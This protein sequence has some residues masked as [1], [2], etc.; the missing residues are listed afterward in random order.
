[1]SLICYSILYIISHSISVNSNY[2]DSSHERIILHELKKEYNSYGINKNVD[3]LSHFTNKYG[4]IYDKKKTN[5]FSLLSFVLNEDLKRTS[6]GTSCI[7]PNIEYLDKLLSEY[8]I[9]FRKNEDILVKLESLEEKPSS[10]PQ[11]EDQSQCNVNERNTTT[12]NKRSL[13]PW[14]FKINVRYD[15]YPPYRTD[16]KCTCSSCNYIGNNILPKNVYGCLP[17]QKAI[18]V[19]IKKEECGSDGFYIWKP[20]IEYVNVACT[21]GVIQNFISFGKR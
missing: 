4:K 2:V 12:I 20:E 14:K 21:C 5:Q 15:R 10:Y 19:L 8:T 7:N 9:F 6:S 1:M 11:I 3:F 17:V 16:A 13:C 18:P